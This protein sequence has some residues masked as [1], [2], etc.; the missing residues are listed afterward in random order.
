MEPRLG[1]YCCPGIC[2]GLDIACAIG[3]RCQKDFVLPGQISGHGAPGTFRVKEGV[4]AQCTVLH[5]QK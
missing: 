1:C 3:T 4:L 5:H 2:T